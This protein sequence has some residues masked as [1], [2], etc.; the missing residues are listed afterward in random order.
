MGAQIIREKIA[1]IEEKLRM[2]MRE[3]G[4]A[5]AEGGGWHDNSA[6]DILQQEELM[7]RE[8]LRNLKEQLWESERE[9]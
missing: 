9:T 4:E 5:A 3:K 7:L 1:A 8:R 2:V 6:F